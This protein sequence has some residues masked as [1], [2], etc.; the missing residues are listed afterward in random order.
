[1][2]LLFFE[3]NDTNEPNAYQLVLVNVRDEYYT[4]PTQNAE[5]WSDHSDVIGGRDLLPGREGGTWLAMNKENRKIGVLLNILQPASE[6]DSGKLG[7]GFIVND[8][9]NGDDSHKTYLDT[10]SSQASS[11]NGFLMIAME[12]S[13]QHS[14]LDASYFST[15]FNQPPTTVGNGIYG[16]GN[17]LDI[18]NPWPKVS[19]GKKRFES[20]LSGHRT[21]NTK[22]QLVE[23]LFEM[24]G[25]KTLL[26]LD[27]QML[28]QGQSFK[29]GNLERL[30]SVFVEIPETKY[31]SR[32]WTIILVDG[33]GD[34]DYIENTMKEPIQC[35]PQGVTSD[36]S[37][38][39]HSFSLS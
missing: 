23:E 3:L 25:D 19:H 14:G 27:N 22:E 26:P 15:H 5:F 13:R 8:Y 1:M 29:I 34:V 39:N 9:V 10:L 37:L 30:S 17:S 28:K 16:F 36:W 20:I 31:G 18:H 21:T 35:G 38:S 6:L 32:T 4:R 12:V 7:R 11:Y 33:N 2:C 24:L